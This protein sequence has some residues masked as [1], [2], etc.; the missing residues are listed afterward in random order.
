[1]TGGGD[2]AGLGVL[3][4]RFRTVLRRLAAADRLTV[5]TRRVSTHLEL[6]GLLKAHDG[7]RALLFVDVMESPMPVVGNLLASPANVEA[8]LGL[9]RHGIRAAMDRA[10][11]CPLP[12]LRV[13]GLGRDTAPAQA[14][15]TTAPFDLAELLPVLRHAPGDGG[16]FVT[17]GVVLVRDPE[18]GVHNASYHRM[19]LLGG[20]RTA[21]KL[22]HG[23][24]LRAAHERAMARGEDLPVVVCLGPDAALLYAAALMG[25]QMPESADELAAAGGLA[26][27]PLEVAE[28]VTSDLPVPAHAEIVLEG[29]ISPTE[30]APEGPFAEFLG[31]PSDDGPAPV[32]TVDAVTHRSDPIYF[33]VN[34]A[35]RETI[36]LRK[37]VLEASALR[38]LRAAVPIVSDVALTAG[39]LY[40]FHLVVQ[41][42]KR[43]ARDDGL[44]RNAMLAAFGALKDLDQVIVV[45]DD[46]DVHDPVDV[47]WAVA[48]RMEASRDLLVVPGA[49]GHEYVR[50]S[51]HGVRAKLGI[52]A[53]VAHAERARFARAPFLEATLTPSDTTPASTYAPLAG[54]LTD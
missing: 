42:A 8:A 36:M 4:T 32:V 41:V 19:Q 2:G 49:R 39:G 33:A 23:R 22:D 24:H 47:E 38:A 25:S 50:V 48:T 14:V 12:P 9:D 18:T 3:D 5:V 29:R 10:L 52:D 28:A 20:N 45:D 13:S 31:Y 43:S 26:G 17:S 7:D 16:R 1:M 44:Q 27:A 40:R 53:T 46:I 15:V 34:G 54:L 30:T 11:A 21:I 6:A 51:D 37:Y 35:G